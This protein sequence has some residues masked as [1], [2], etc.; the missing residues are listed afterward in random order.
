MAD[1]CVALVVAKASCVATC[2]DGPVRDANAVSMLATAVPLAA[3]CKA[4]EC[5]AKLGFILSS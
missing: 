2:A 4:G 1:E 5:C 3:C